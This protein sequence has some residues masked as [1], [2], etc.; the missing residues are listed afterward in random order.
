VE[1]STGTD[2]LV[3]SLR[4]GQGFS[5]C[6]EA[7]SSAARARSLPMYPELSPAQVERVGV[8]YEPQRR[9]RD[10]IPSSSP[11]V[12]AFGLGVGILIGL[13]GIGGGSVM[14]P[15][16]VLVVGVQPVVAIGTDLAYGA[17]T[18]TVGGWRHLRSGAVDLGVSKWLAVGSVPGSIAGVLAADA[19]HNR[20]GHDFDSTLLA[21]VAIAL[22]VV[23]LSVL[24]RALFG[25]PREQH[26]VPL[27]GA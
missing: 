12:I 20:Y 25:V 11:S 21:L 1:I 22:L 2:A 26:S 27:G 23:A 24:A 7:A 13:T 16:L 3:P 9:R 6:S 8:R 5:A 4:A 18:K 14:T 19:L 15:L 10:A 17:I